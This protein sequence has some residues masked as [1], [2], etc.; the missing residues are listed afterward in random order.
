MHSFECYLIPLISI[1]DVD[2][3]RWN[4]VFRIIGNCRQKLDSEAVIACCPSMINYVS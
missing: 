2:R 4:F 3:Y 1:C